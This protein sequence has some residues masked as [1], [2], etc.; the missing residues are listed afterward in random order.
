[1]EV[2]LTSGG[3]IFQQVGATVDRIPYAKVMTGSLWVQDAELVDQL[4]G[5]SEV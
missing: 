3:I 2:K 1:M 4:V 5:S